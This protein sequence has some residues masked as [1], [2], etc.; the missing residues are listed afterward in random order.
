MRGVGISDMTAPPVTDPPASDSDTTAPPDP[1]PVAGRSPSERLEVDA[2]LQRL[3]RLLGL[4]PGELGYLA[5]ISSADLRALRAQITQVLFDGNGALARLGAATRLLPAALTASL[6]ERIFGPVLA[7]RV[8]GTVEPGRAVE[9][10]ARLPVDFLADVASELDPRRV[11]AILAAIPAPTV[12]AVTR[13]LVQRREW[14]AMGSFYGFLPDASIQA[15]MAETDAHAL[16][17]IAF[18]LEDKSR[19]S[20][21][22][23]IGGSVRLGE[24]VACA[25]A[26]GLTEQLAA[27]AAHLTPEQAAAVTRTLSLERPARL[28]S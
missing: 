22:L 28:G 23:E 18:V 6:T 2:E 8:A 1:T 3:G 11:A 13:V 9:I 24:L 19:L 15:A 16:L 20:H 26:E 4:A 12:A 14:V 7:A 25:E 17:Q 10:A 21:V 27:L 5:D